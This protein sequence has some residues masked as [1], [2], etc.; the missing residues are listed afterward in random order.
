MPFFGGFFW[1]LVGGEGKWVGWNVDGYVVEV[2]RYPLE[3]W[4]VCC[5]ISKSK[6]V[7]W[8]RR[9]DDGR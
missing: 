2:D 9:E 3:V 1:V 7:V 4:K 6:A 8:L 5:G